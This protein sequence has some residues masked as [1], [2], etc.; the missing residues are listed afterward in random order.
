MK[1]CAGLDAFLKESRSNG[2][3]H[4]RA[5]K[6]NKVI[7]NRILSRL[8][9]VGLFFIIFFISAKNNSVGSKERT[10][11]CG[12]TAQVPFEASQL[13]SFVS[14]KSLS[15]HLQALLEKWDQPKTLAHSLLHVIWWCTL[16][17]HVDED[18]KT[19]HLRFYPC[20]RVEIRNVIHPCVT[21]ETN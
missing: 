7:T 3:W 10:G 5:Y 18:L 16:Y 1:L 2:F 19:Q 14:V 8:V 15:S 12:R 11:V 6:F 21:L 20:C 13:F 9:Q 4:L 17:P